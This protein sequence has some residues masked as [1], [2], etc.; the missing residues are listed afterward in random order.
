M[1]KQSVAALQ[2]KIKDLEKANKE[3]KQEIEEY[4]FN[5]KEAD[6]KVQDAQGRMDIMSDKE[7][8]SFKVLLKDALPSMDKAPSNGNMAVA[9]IIAGMAHQ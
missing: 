6:A 8:S 4:D 1:G 7:K 9:A 2:Q 3:L 5:L